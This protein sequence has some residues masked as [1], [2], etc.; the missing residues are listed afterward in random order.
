M[1]TAHSIL[2][3]EVQVWCSKRRKSAKLDQTRDST[4]LFVLLF[5]NLLLETRFL[6]SSQADL[7]HTTQS[8]MALCFL[9]PC[10]CVPSV[11]IKAMNTKNGLWG[12]SFVSQAFN[13]SVWEAAA[14]RFV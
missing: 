3:P 5:F 4:K 6:Y 14:H 9:S 13:V 8:S 1:Q 2:G 11:G 10:L 7:K 12:L